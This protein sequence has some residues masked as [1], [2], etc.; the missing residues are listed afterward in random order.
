VIAGSENAVGFGGYFTR[1]GGTASQGIA[2]YR[3]LPKA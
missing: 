3:H 2:L 1:I